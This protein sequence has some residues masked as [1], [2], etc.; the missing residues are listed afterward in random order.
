MSAHHIVRI[1]ADLGALFGQEELVISG[2]FKAC[3]R[4]LEQNGEEVGSA[5]L[6][7]GLFLLPHESLIQFLLTQPT[8]YK[9]IEI[10][11][12][13]LGNSEEQFTP[14]NNFED[15]SLSRY[16]LSRYLG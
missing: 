16:Q 12:F 1:S 6:S 7:G 2:A 11:V 5:P 13:S 3:L 15:D 8:H 4:Y 10:A 9:Q 14:K